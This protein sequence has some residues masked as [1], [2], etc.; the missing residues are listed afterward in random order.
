[1]LDSI[2]KR[3]GDK[4]LSIGENS[5]V[6]VLGSQ[7]VHNKIGVQ[8]KDTSSAWLRDCRLEAHG[9]FASA[10]RK[11]W[12]YGRGG[13]LLLEDCA[14]EGSGSVESLKRSRVLLKSR[15]GE[16]SSKVETWADLK[17]VDLWT[18]EAGVQVG[19]SVS[20]FE[21]R[22]RTQLARPRLRAERLGAN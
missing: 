6:L 8:S 10:L 22:F 7:L 21:D 16:A 5:Q 20:V 14:F 9:L 11:N 4:G 19:F 1:V 15:P 12:R 2:F 3:S 18:E 17:R 13:K